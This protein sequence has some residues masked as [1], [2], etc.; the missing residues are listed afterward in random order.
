[1][2]KIK[3]LFLISI[4]ILNACFAGDLKKKPAE[5]KKSWLSKETSKNVL[6]KKNE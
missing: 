1:M 2:Q 5:E 6:M 3:N 4:I